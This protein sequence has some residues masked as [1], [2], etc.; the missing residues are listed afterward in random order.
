VNVGGPSLRRRVRHWWRKP[1]GKLSAV[2]LAALAVATVVLVGFT[3]TMSDPE[4]S[5]STRVTQPEPTGSTSVRQPEP[6]DVQPAAP[7]PPKVSVAKSSTFES[8]LPNGFRVHETDLNETGMHVADGV[9]VHGKPTADAGASYLEAQLPDDVQRLGADVV[10]NGDKPG[11][12]ALVAWQKSIYD[13][14]AAG[15]PI[16][17]SGLH[18]VADP[19]GW[20]LG[21]YHDGREDVLERN[22]FQ[23]VLETDGQTG[24]RFE[25]YRKGR[26]AWVVDPDGVITGPIRDKRIAD[27]AG[28]WASWE[29]YEFSG[30]LTPAAFA[31]VWAG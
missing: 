13:E 22:N 18:F 4:P 31:K 11:S 24:Y 30:D 17:N 5:G 26:S 21:I 15:R 28:P 14:R 6:T 10:F 27:W 29:L 9:L 19:N 2:G 3:L 7:Q 20:H 8:K 1:G 16:P 23:Q 25:V 12:I